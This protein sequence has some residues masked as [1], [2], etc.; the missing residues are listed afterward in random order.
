M[1]SND[2]EVN[3]GLV[4]GILYDFELLIWVVW[5]VV[6]LKFE[7]LGIMFRGEFF[8]YRFFRFDW[9]YVLFVWF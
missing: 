1:E 3:Y 4:F 6:G 8:L 9:F 2:Y 5:E 7:K